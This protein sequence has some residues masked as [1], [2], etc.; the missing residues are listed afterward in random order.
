MCTQLPRLL[1]LHSLAGVVLL[2]L[3][4][5]AVAAPVYQ[6]KDAS[7]QTVYSDQPPPSGVP[8]QQLTMPPA[9]SA[10]DVEAAQQRTK[11]MQ[12][13]TE[14]LS[15]ERRQR[16]QRAAEAAKQAAPEQPLVPDEEPGQNSYYDPQNYYPPRQPISRPLPPRGDMTVRPA[17]PIARPGRAR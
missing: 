1:R 14:Q 4:P 15:E 16:E 8:A 11:A 3:A 13:Q 10:A 5:V 12:E 9:P 17:H 6:W 7:G 2:A